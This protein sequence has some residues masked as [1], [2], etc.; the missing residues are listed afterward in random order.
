MFMLSL[1]I[2]QQHLTFKLNILG[3]FYHFYKN[4]NLYINMLKYINS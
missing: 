1:L 2:N 4:P 3:I